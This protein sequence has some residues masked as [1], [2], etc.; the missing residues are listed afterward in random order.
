[1][2]E[3][4]RTRVRTQD[5]KLV[6]YVDAAAPHFNLP[7]VDL[8]RYGSDVQA[9]AR[10]VAAEEA[11]RGFNPADDHGMRAAV[12]RLADEEHGLLITLHHLVADAASIAVL[13]G[14]L[15][16][17]YEARSAGL[18]SPLSPLP[19]QFA[20]YICWLDRW[21]ASADGRRQEA[22]W[23]KRLGPPWPRLELPSS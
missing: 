6:Q 13:L 20:D 1:R 8:A 7:L 9:I 19:V 21:L 15:A 12:L 16:R 3:T 22:Y 5:G 17:A 10:Q 11:N 4:L 14:D 2:H 18:P 23:H